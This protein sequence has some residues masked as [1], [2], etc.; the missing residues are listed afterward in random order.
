MELPYY[1]VIPKQDPHKSLVKDKVI[2]LGDAA[3]QVKPTTGGGLIMGFT[4]AEMAS[5]VTSQ[6]LEAEN[7]AMLENYSKLYRDKFKKELKV[8]LMVH[9]VFKSL[10]NS[11]LEYMFIKLKEE[12]AEDIISEYG[13][14]DTQSPLI[15]EMIK[16]G[17]IFSILPKML[18]R[19]LSGLWK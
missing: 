10:S 4:S 17:I 16:Q 13:D 2:L 14:M 5:N 19:R 3:S 11:D 9:K 8:Q 7:T 1:G 6:A 12:G 18:S 15:K